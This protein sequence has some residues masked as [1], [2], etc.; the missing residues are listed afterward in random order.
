MTAKAKTKR[1]KKALGTVPEQLA[2][3]K[4]MKVSELREVYL[5]VFDVPSRSRNKDYL[6]KKV[7]LGIQD[8]EEPLSTKTK[9]RLKK[10]SGK[11]L[12]KRRR[13]SRRPKQDSTTFERD[14]RLPEAGTVLT[15]EFQE[16]EFS[17]TILTDG[18]EYDGKRYRSLSGVAREISGTNWNGFTFFGLS[19]R[20]K[21]AAQ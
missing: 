6:Y 3:L 2:A 8:R 19:K 13:S 9:K 11:S 15:K 20:G 12:T 4:K 21:K 1:A 5:E 17:V 16:E 18:F 7:A 10:I 14:P